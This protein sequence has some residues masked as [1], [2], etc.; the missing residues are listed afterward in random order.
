MDAISSQSP[1]EERVVRF[2][3]TDGMPLN[4]LHVRGPDP[5]TRGPLL[6]VHGGDDSRLAAQCSEQIF[7][8]AKE[9]KEIVIYPGAE[10]GLNEC[11]DELHDLLRGWIPERFETQK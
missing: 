5:P 9:P 1:L 6:L 8:W 11:K 10:H 7:E 2:T 4:L 3:A